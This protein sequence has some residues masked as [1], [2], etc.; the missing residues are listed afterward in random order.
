M[1]VPK[2][3]ISTL[4]DK[5][6]VFN[7]LTVVPVD[8]IETKAIPYIRSVIE[9]GEYDKHFDAF[10]KYF[11]KTW[12]GLYDPAYWNVNAVVHADAAESLLQNRTNNPLERFNRKFNDAFASAHPNVPQFVETIKRLSQDY[13]SDLDNV[14]TGRCRL[15]THLPVSQYCIPNDYHNFQSRE[16][17]VCS[18]YSRIAHLTYLMNTTHYDWDDECMYKVTKKNINVVRG[19]E[20]LVAHRVQ[21]KHQK[22]GILNV[23][24]EDVVSVE[25]VLKYMG[26]PSSNYITTE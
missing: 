2:D 16:S 19:E 24:C 17:I 20:V 9:E 26:L 10:W 13:V 5:N 23:E 14:K 8:E 15:S 21:C 22:D 4:I 12:M 25:E 1:S 6:G 11:I 18:R 7:I 3:I